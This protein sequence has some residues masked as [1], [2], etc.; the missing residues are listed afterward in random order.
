MGEWREVNLDR[1]LDR[2][3]NRNETWIDGMLRMSNYLSQRSPRDA[4]GAIILAVT[5]RR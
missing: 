5:Q 4:Y 1:D 2:D 3:R